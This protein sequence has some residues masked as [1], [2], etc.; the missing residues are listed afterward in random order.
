M[1]T[2]VI[3]GRPNTG[4]STLF[5]RIVGGHIAITLEEPG[6]TRD[7]IIR[8]AEWCGRS[9]SLVD[10]GGLVP[11]SAVELEREVNRQVALALDEA[12]VVVLVV[13]GAAGLAPLD[14]EIAQRLRRRGVG[15]LLCV[16]KSDAKRRFDPAEFHRLG[17]AAFFEISAEHGTGVDA[18][19]DEIV[20]RLPLEKRTRTRPAIP[21]AILGRPNTGKS[22][23]LNRLLDRE[24]AIVSPLPGTTRD[25]IEDEF[26]C[27][28]QRF[29]LIDTAGIRRR[30]KV[31][32]PVEF[33]SVSRT[34]D[35]I[36]RCEI[37]LIVI[38]ATEGPANQDKRI[39]NLV[40]EHDKGIVVVAN[41]MDIVPR[42]LVKK[43]QDYVRAELE[44]ADYAPIVFT[45]ALKGRGITEVI[46]QAN[47]VHAAGM[48]QVSA[49]ALRQTVLEELKAKPPRRG[50]RVLGL[51]QVGTRPPAF[52]LR[53]S[54]PKAAD[55]PF[56]RRVLNLL[57]AGFG[58]SG[59]PVRL[60]IAR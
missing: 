45:S 12:T 10:T 34:L 32:Q 23:L 38:D 24:R 5:N 55:L 54:D 31:E 35:T 40:E 51:V 44:F 14:E 30:T 36:R 41:K 21:L 2:V 9:F 48:V 39:I 53:L 20:R 47:A 25:A 42:E 3:V 43:V 17:A 57:R 50:C 18:L 15:F 11:D 33:Y 56:R 13:D 29:R 7:R 26:D 37:A 16:N 28:G 49:A 27:A 58:F 4:K 19:L 8:R 46:R 60:R 1:A 59:W 22:T 6:I 52:R